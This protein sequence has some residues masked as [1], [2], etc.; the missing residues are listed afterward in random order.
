MQNEKSVRCDRKR[1]VLQ[2]AE[3]VRRKMGA[4]AGAEGKSRQV[5]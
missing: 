2:E 4:E 5:W 1:M 3:T